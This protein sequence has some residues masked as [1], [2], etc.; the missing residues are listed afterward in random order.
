MWISPGLFGATSYSFCGNCR[1]EPIVP[2]PQRPMSCPGPGG[3]LPTALPSNSEY[4]TYSS[5]SG[6]LPGQDRWPPSTPRTSSSQSHPSTTAS[7]PQG[8]SSAAFSNYMPVCP[9]CTHICKGAPRKRPS[10][11]IRMCMRMP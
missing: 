2:H 7:S 6:S 8:T 10:G 5:P 11:P 1:N 4:S 9:F 3:L